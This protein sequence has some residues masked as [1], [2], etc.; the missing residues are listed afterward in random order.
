V[1]ERDRIVMSRVL[2]GGQKDDG[3]F[4]LAF[5]QSIGAEGIFAAAWEMIGELRAM[6]GQDGSEP[7]L[8]RSVVRVVRRGR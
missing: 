3:A 5:W 8:Q 2:R 1:V 4:D 6:R 7:R